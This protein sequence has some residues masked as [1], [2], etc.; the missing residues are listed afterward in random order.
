MPKYKKD[1]LTAIS[2]SDPSDYGKYRIL[3]KKRQCRKGYVKLKRTWPGRL[4]A[5]GTK[6]PPKW[7]CV[8][9]RKG[10]ENLE[11]LVMSLNSSF[12]KWI[13][14]CEKLKAT[15]K[16]SS[17]QNCIPGY[18]KVQKMKEH[19][20]GNSIQDYCVSNWKSCF[21]YDADNHSCRQCKDT[22]LME[23][24]TEDTNGKSYCKMNLH[25]VTIEVVL[26]ILAFMLFI[27]LIFIKPEIDFK[28]RQPVIVADKDD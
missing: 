27:Y 2:C 5:D 21:D 24:T 18:H 25:L 20:T 11:A 10:C 1:I 8:T 4:L 6:K 13:K 19:K 22:W 7:Y 3:S 28:N 23:L 12:E 15:I 17:T 26:L 16:V 14:I 9:P